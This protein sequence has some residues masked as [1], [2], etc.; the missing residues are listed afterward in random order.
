MRKDIF[1]FCLAS[2]G[3]SERLGAEI[4]W[5]LMVVDA[6]CH[7]GSPLRLTLDHLHVAFPCDCLASFQYGGW[8]EDEHPK[9]IKWK[10]YYDFWLSV[11]RHI[12]LFPLESQAQEVL[13]GEN[14][15]NSPHAPHLSV[16]EYQHHMVRKA[17]WWDILVRI[18]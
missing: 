12:M 3:A 1:P 18:S 5:S 2:A 6:G 8:V 13:R 10:H 15:D 7:L 17:H 11:R 16:K 4:I 14:I 9:M